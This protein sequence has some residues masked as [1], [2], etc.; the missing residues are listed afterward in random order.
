MEIFITIIIVA[1]A[2]YSLYKSLAK[3]TKGGCSGCSS[4][5]PSKGS[6]SSITKDDSNL[7]KFIK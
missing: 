3:S 5:C 4:N 2:G 7:I 6:C 1:F